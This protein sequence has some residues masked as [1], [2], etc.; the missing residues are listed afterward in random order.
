MSFGWRDLSVE[1]V[2]VH[3][4]S[5]KY[6]KTKAHLHGEKWLAVYQ[7]LFRVGG[8]ALIALLVSTCVG[9]IRAR[10]PMRPAIFL[11]G[12]IGL[13]LY[14]VPVMTLSYDFR[15]GIPAETFV[16]VSGLLG[17]MAWSRSGTEYSA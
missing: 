8:L 10:G 11:F 9:I 4:L 7:N 17:A 6:H 12:L 15:Y 5:K 3:E 1:R 16:V 2:V 14:L 13:G